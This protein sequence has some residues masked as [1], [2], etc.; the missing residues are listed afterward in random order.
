MPR[1]IAKSRVW[2]PVSRQCGHLRR[3]GRLDR[4]GRGR[5]SRFMS[6]STAPKHHLLITGTG[7]SGTSFL[8]RWL[9]ALG[10]ETHFSRFGEYASWDDEANAGA[11][12]LPLPELDPDMPYVV[13]SP[14]VSEFMDQLLADPGIALDAVIV[15][16]RDLMDVAASRTILELRDMTAGNDWATAMNGPWAHRGVT[17]GGI[18]YSLHPLDQARILALGFHHLVERLTA[19]EVPLVLLSFPRLVQDPDYLYRK[20]S[21]VLPEGV[22][23]AAAREAHARMAD[24]SKIRVGKGGRDETIERLD[25]VAQNRE[26]D[27]LRRRVADLEGEAQALRDHAGAIENSRMWR[28]LGP[29]RNSLH[30]LRSRR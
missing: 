30:R 23:A 21:F 7:R 20:L 16:M 14:W 29:L 10:L 24:P 6:E 1:P 13:K 5:H 2:R 15:P 17:P 22:D 3:S 27:R 8:V 18:V 19:A 11:E 12:N 25:R 26:I 9:D 4:T 28:A